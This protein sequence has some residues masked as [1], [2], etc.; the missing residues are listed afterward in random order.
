MPEYALFL[1]CMI[2]LRLPYMESS[3]RELLKRFDV[4]LIEMQ[5]GW[6]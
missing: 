6:V 1:G 5:E 3:A 4:E 2:P